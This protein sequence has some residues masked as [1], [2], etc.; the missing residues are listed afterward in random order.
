MGAFLTWLDAPAIDMRWERRVLADGG[1]L[2]HDVG[3]KHMPL[4]LQFPAEHTG[5]GTCTFRDL[6]H[7]WHQ[8][9]GM[10]TALVD[11]S[12]LLCMHLDRMYQNSAGTVCKSQC[13]VEIP[14]EIKLPCFAGQTMDVEWIPYQI[15]ALAAHLGDTDG[16]HYRAALKLKPSVTADLTPFRWLLTDD[17]VPAQKT[18]HLPEWLTQNLTTIWLARMDCACLPEHSMDPAAS[19]YDAA[20]WDLEAFHKLLQDVPVGKQT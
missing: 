4:F 18:W 8:V 17:G 2:I 1:I 10:S 6:L 14:D 16:G 7:V 11:T 5:D 20:H 3:S 12:P 9:Q 15:T 19:T 13:D